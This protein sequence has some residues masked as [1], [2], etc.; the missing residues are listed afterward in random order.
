MYINLKP[1]LQLGVKPT[2]K[3]SANNIS[4]N[5]NNYENQKSYANHPIMDLACVQSN[6]KIQKVSFKSNSPIE[7]DAEA[8]ANKYLTS[9]FLEKVN[10][11]SKD[12]EVAET[13]KKT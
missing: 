3:L 2:K 5:S 4:V 10:S 6:Y 9:E 7:T 13:Y 8:I 1:N 12:K 11:G